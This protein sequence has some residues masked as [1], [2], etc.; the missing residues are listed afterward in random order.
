MRKKKEKLNRTSV[1]QS[2]LMISVSTI[3][4]FTFV[5]LPLLWIVRW[6]MFSYRGFGEPTFVG[7][8]HFVRAFTRTP[9][10]WMAVGNTFVFAICKLAIEISMALVLG[11]MLT[12]KLRGTTFFRS[13]YFM[14]S[15]ISVAI[16]GVIFTY[17]FQNGK[18]KKRSSGKFR[19]S[20]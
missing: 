15:M 6:C 4:L 17:F 7:L 14:P 3:G 12:K 9:K 10:Y 18:R 13:I 19:F 1:I 20:K 8:D 11:Y 2:Y 5:V 16:I